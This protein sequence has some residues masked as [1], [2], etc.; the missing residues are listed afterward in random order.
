MR[1]IVFGGSG[2][3]G[4]H[5]ADAL[6]ARGIDAV[7]YDLEPSPYLAEGQRMV[8]GDIL[9]ADAVRE[10]TDGCDYVY[11]FAGLADIDDAAQRPLDTVSLNIMGNLHVMDAAV[12]AG[13]KRFVYASSIYVYSQ[14]GGFYRCSKQASE[15][16]VEEYRR[17]SGLSFTILRYGTLYGPRATDSNSVHRYLSQAVRTGR[18][19]CMGSGEE[20]REY[21]HVRD[22]ASLSVDVLADEY[23]DRHITITGH[24]PVPFGDMLRTISEILGGNVEIE[25]TGESYPDHYSYTPYSWTPTI[26]HK[27]VGTC[28]TDIGQGLLECLTEIRSEDEQAG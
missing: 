16:Y 25:F 24:N 11:N 13:A 3:L 22:A 7:I 21:V 8:V 27:L 4:S 1:A 14:K 10:A 5:V 9:D 19:V 18:I 6:T 17:R 28:Y 20:V 23:A 2:F 15:T 12:A 26:G